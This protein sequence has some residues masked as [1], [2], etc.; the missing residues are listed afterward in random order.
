[1][2]S[3]RGAQGFVSE[4]G[5]IVSFGEL[6]KPMVHCADNRA[7]AE[8]WVPQHFAYCLLP[9]LARRVRIASGQLQVKRN[10]AIARIS[11]QE[12]NLRPFKFASRYEIFTADSVPTITFCTVLEE[13]MREHNTRKI[14]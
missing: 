4:E 3:R 12:D 10:K 6:V 5:E 14:G 9:E 8:L 2:F 1:M 7:Y 13:V 11:G